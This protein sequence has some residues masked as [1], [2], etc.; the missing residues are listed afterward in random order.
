MSL[1]NLAE[2]RGAPRRRV[3]LSMLIGDQI[4]E[5]IDVSTRGIRFAAVT[6]LSPGSLISFALLVPGTG[7][8]LRFNC[9]G[10]VVR[11]EGMTGGSEVAATIDSLNLEPNR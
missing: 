2:R 11:V 4:T 7:D 3:H 9:E 10:R 1:Q 8:A 6:P 5:T